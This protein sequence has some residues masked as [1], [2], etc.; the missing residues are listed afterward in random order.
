MVAGWIMGPNFKG[1]KISRAIDTI[2]SLRKQMKKEKNQPDSTMIPHV[3][4]FVCLFVFWE[5]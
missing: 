3:D 2:N 5:K 1:H 4:F